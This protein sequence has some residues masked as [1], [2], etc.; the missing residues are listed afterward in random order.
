[1]G[2][3][4]E[5]AQIVA[6]H[7]PALPVY[8]LAQPAIEDLLC[9]A[10]HLQGEFLPI[11]LET[12]DEVWDRRFSQTSLYIIDL[13]V[14]EHDDIPITPFLKRLSEHCGKE[15]H[16]RPLIVAITAT[17]EAGRQVGPFAS[18]VVKPFHLSQLFTLLFE[19]RKAPR[20][21]RP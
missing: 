16:Q 19:V 5:I 13:D 15:G 10:L 1:M 20:S 3:E 18:L 11:P 17:H 6:Q 21:V 8:V 4:Q 7:W 14:L 12:A 9:C 2:Y